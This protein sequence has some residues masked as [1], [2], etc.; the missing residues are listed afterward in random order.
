MNELQITKAQEKYIANYNKAVAGCVKSAWG[1]AEVVHKTVNA[2]DFEEVFGNIDGY[3][4]H[5]NV[6]KSTISKLAKSYERKLLIDAQET[7][8]DKNFSVGQIEEFGKIPVAETLTFIE[9]QEVTTADTTKVIREKVK[10]YC[11]PVVESD[12]SEELEESD[13]SEMQEENTNESMFI[14]YKGTEYQITNDE[15]INAIIHLLKGE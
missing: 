6:A 14:S 3:A 11:D 5:L 1:L 12:E 4:K 2:K 9:E 15:I 7:D 13:E 10:N 8:A